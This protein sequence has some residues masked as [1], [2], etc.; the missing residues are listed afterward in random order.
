MRWAPLSRDQYVEAKSLLA[1][2]L[3]AAQGDRVAAANSIEG[4]VPYLDH[5]VI[6]F[7]NRLPPSFKIRGLTEKYLLRRALAGLLP[8]DIVTRTKQPYRA[9][10]SA[11][12]F[13]N[14]K[15]PDYVS[16]LLSAERIRKAG[17]FDAASV[18]RLLDKCRAG[19]A[20]GFADNQAFV[21]I[22]STML[23]DETFLRG[24]HDA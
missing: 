24:K 5:R 17:Y 13:V 22:L 3:L 8:T 2:Y 11:S 18:G 21:G 12:F 14:G 23:L 10:D 20:T 16:D 6:E 9:P 7:G 4:R 15:A 19:K 1:A